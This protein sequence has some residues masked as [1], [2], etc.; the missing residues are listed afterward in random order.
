MSTAG[1]DKEGWEREHAP[2]AREA[3]AEFSLVVRDRCV[4]EAEVALV[5]DAAAL[6]EQVEV[7][8][9]PAVERLVPPYVAPQQLERAAVVDPAA[10][11]R[12]RRSGGRHAQVREV[13]RSAP[14]PS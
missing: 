14:R 3:A 8:D 5:V 12:G 11:M 10:C 4:D 2:V 1:P 13:L 9:R 7:G 6:D